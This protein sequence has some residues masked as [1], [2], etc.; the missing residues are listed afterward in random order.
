MTERLLLL[1]LGAFTSVR[2]DAQQRRGSTFGSVPIRE[3][4]RRPGP[5]TIG[6]EW[7]LPWRHRCHTYPAVSG[8]PY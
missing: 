3:R 2:R 1:A 6:N 5:G 4:V 7:P 8:Q